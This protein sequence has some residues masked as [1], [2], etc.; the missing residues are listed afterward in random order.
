MG[1]AEEILKRIA[2]INARLLV[3]EPRNLGLRELV[4]KRQIQ[5]LQFRQPRAALPPDV[6]VIRPEPASR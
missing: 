1:R 6:T 5:A 2:T 3:I 4:T